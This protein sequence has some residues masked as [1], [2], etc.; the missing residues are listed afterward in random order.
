M[1]DPTDNHA[2][3][4]VAFFA[5]R[6]VVRAVAT[7]IGGARAIERHYG[8]RFTS[9]RAADRRRRSAPARRRR[10]RPTA[11]PTP[12][13]PPPMP[14]EPRR[15][16]TSRRKELEEQIVLLTKVKHSD[17]TPLPMPVPPPDDYQPRRTCPQNRASRSC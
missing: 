1:A 5:D 16:A 4:E 6:F 14:K 2:V 8:V 7:E 13:P 11:R 15:R 12:S 9:P 17:A 3:D 10:R